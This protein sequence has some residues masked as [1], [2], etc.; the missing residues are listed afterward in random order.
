MK[1]FDSW[2]L[3]ISLKSNEFAEWNECTLIQAF[4]YFFSAMNILDLNIVRFKLI[5]M[6]L[7]HVA[8]AFASIRSQKKPFSVTEITISA[9]CIHWENSSNVFFL[10]FMQSTPICN[11]WMSFLL[12][13]IR[14]IFFWSETNKRIF[15][16]LH[17]FQLFSKE[18]RSE[19][20]GIK[21]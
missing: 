21:F 13:T 9:I 15:S 11:C 2:Q 7:I 6:H 1:R 18:N 19:T 8:L 16:R 3:H 14:L 4:L 20:N 17:F 5:S 12:I 10:V